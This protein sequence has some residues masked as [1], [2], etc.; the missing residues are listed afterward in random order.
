MPTLLIQI[1]GIDVTA[2]STQGPEKSLLLLTG[3]GL[4]GVT[5]L[6]IPDAFE[7]G[8]LSRSTS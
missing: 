5:I 7:L 8:K 3:S 6:Q 1:E 4:G 2:R